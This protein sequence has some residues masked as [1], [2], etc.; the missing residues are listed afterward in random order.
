MSPQGRPHRRAVMLVLLMLVSLMPMPLSSAGGGTG[1]LSM[2]ET[3]MQTEVVDLAGGSSNASMG[4]SIPRD[5]TFDG[6]NLVVD[7]DDDLDTPGQVWLDID[8]DG[9]KEWAYEGQGYG[10]LGHQSEFAHGGS[11]DFVVS[12]TSSNSTTV[13]SDILL[14]EN[15]IVGAAAATLSFIPDVTTAFQAIGDIVD[16]QTGDMDG[17]G[18]DE[19]IVLSAN[20]ATTGNGTAFAVLDYNQSSRQLEMSNWTETCTDAR[21]FDMGDFNNDSRLDVF[22]WAV[23]DVDACLHLSN[24]TA[25]NASHPST[26]FPF[27]ATLNVTMD[28][29]LKKAVVGDFTNDGYADIVSIHGQ[30]STQGVFVLKPFS[31]AGNGFLTN[32]TATIF[33]NG[34][35]NT[36]NLQDIY[37]GAMSN[38]NS[39]VSAL[40][41]HR[42]GW[43]SSYQ[44]WEL[45]WDG[46]FITQAT[47]P[48]RFSDL[49]AGMLPVDIDGDGDTDFVSGAGSFEHVV[50]IND[51][52]T[53]AVSEHSDY[54]PFTTINA[55]FGDHDGDGIP[56]LFMVESGN[57]D[58]STATIEGNLT[59]R[60]TNGS[61]LDLASP[62]RLQPWSMPLDVI[63]GDL[64][65]DGHEEQVVVAG[66]TQLGIFVGGWH[67]IGLDV[68][69]DG[70]DEISVEAYA[71]TANSTHHGVVTVTDTVGAIKTALTGHVLGL[72]TSSDAYGVSMA[73]LNFTL[74]TTANGVLNTT[75][76]D[77]AYDA[78]ITI[79]QNPSVVGNLSNLVN[80]RMQLGTGDFRLPL[81]FNSTEAGVLRLTDVLGPYLDGAPNIARPPMPVLSLTTLTPYMIE[82]AWQDVGEFSEGLLGF[83][84]YRVPNGTAIDLNSPYA[85]AGLNMTVDANIS[86]GD[87]YDYAVRSRHVFGLR[88]NLSALLTVEVPYPAPP[89]P[90]VNLTASDLM[91]DEGGHIAVDWD[92]AEITSAQAYRVYVSPQAFNATAGLNPVTVLDVDASRPIVVNTTSD[93]VNGTTVL[94]PSGPLQDGTPYHLGVV[95]VDEHGNTSSLVTTGPVS[96]RDDR[97]RTPSVTLTLDGDT[98]A[99]GV[100]LLPVNGPVKA[101]V[102]ATAGGEPLS[103]AAVWFLL[104]HAENGFS[105]NMTG[106]TDASGQF[107][108]LEVTSLMVW[109]PTMAQN[110]G[111]LALT[112]GVLAETDDPMRQPW[113][114]AAGSM[115]VYNTVQM[116]VVA[117]T[118][119][120]VVDNGTWSID[121]SVQETMVEQTGA[122]P[123]VAVDYVMLSADGNELGNGTLLPNAGAYVLDSASIEAAVVRFSIDNDGRPWVLMPA[124]HEVTLVR[125]NDNG[126]VD[127][128]NQTG[129]GQGGTGEPAE[130]TALLPLEISDCTVRSFP[131]DVTVDQNTQCLLR[132][133]NAF[134]VTVSVDTTTETLGL[135]RFD[136]LQGDGDI[137]ANGERQVVWSMTTLRS[138]ADESGTA[139]EATTTY[140]LTTAS[141]ASLSY[142]GSISLSWTLEEATVDDGSSDASGGSN[143]LI[144][145]LGAVAIV[146]G[147]AVAFVL[148]R[149]PEDDEDFSEDDLDDFEY[150]PVGSTRDDAVDLTTTSS[151][152]Q[153]K[154]TGASI[155]ELQP[156][157]KER[158]SDALISEASGADY[159]DEDDADPS[160][161]SYEEASTDEG[162]NVD[163][164]GTEWYEDEVG[165]WWYREAGQEDWSEYNE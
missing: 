37:V 142:D 125:T 153:L 116:E 161:E 141:N 25:V 162:I 22:T 36:A 16:V 5:V 65:G 112:Y 67:R 139:F 154:A 77:I 90:V 97:L 163:E 138:L 119:V 149:R 103:D 88:S 108:G 69:G 164:F 32:A 117:P 46:R 132:N 147:L 10:S 51:G 130:V 100:R 165:T 62:V 93:V 145:G 71:G 59:N 26:A 96:P 107:V 64:D 13:T 99:S 75:L 86:Y 123:S 21:N 6:L 157:V 72:P 158:P 104:E 118:I 4:L 7:V 14:P 20:N 110:V 122:A 160:S 45:K 102:E 101:T 2:F 159:P 105:R 49:R 146:A 40:V 78:R 85:D 109:E 41:V 80:Q 42:G 150:G 29:R 38:Q 55:S 19:I 151:L 115:T 81:P 18:S 39:D 133:P 128:G 1:T 63:F 83:D 27:N 94:T 131:R 50:A 53:W 91:S 95:A 129:G 58:G 43:G 136:L 23:L 66:E 73:H 54:D 48:D 121:L 124:V 137:P 134:T 9:V 87:V 144:I 61:G 82:I 24:T 79:E 28:D 106:T 15:A 111:E 89:P 56:S 30:G 120:E 44:G 68:E 3:G 148:L 155:E 52:Y 126:G 98:N 135:M 143:G 34:S 70:V 17:D 92:D 152:T 57:S 84:V 74:S 127:P 156:E 47:G 12:N 31:P 140:R 8:E 113:S 76:I 60:P 33:R 11:S 35:T 114:A